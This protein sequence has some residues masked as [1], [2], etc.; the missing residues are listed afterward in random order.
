MFDFLLQSTQ[1]TVFGTILAAGFVYLIS[2]FAIGAIGGS[3]DG[4]GGDHADGNDTVEGD[5]TGEVVS[6]FSPRVIAI[7]L[8]GFGAG[9][10]IATANEMSAFIST[11]SAI[12][13]GLGMGTGGLVVMRM[14]YKQQVSSD[15][16]TSDAIG[17]HGTVM[18]DIVPGS[19]GS[20]DVSVRGHVLTL[21][22]YASDPAMTYR[23]G[24]RVRII[25][26]TSSDA[27]VSL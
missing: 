26:V 9:G 10:A 14:I 17:S 4:H 22:A 11:I 13:S 15:V 21:T 2:S 7:F 12:V 3:D 1:L 20:V 16:S 27:I 18:V 19:F 24:Q 5:H 6:V 25:S 8:V 23:K